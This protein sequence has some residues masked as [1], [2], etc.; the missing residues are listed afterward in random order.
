[1][2]PIQKT[3]GPFPAL[4][5]QIDGSIRPGLPFALRLPPNLL[6]PSE[7]IAGRYFLVRC[8]SNV[9][10]D[11]EGD[12]S[13]FLRRPLFVSGRQPREG[14]DNWQLYLP[15]DTPA[16]AESPT[17]PR[18]GAHVADAGF[19]WLAQR[20]QGGLLNLY[21]P[22]GNGFKLPT[23][24]HNLL[25]LVDHAH[26]PGWFWQ[27]FSL[28]E[29]TLDRG[30]RVTILLRSA[31]DRSVAD[32]IPLLPVQVEVRTASDESG[33]LEQLR[34]TVGWAHCI[35]A[36]VPPLRYGEILRVV[37]ESR[38]HIDKDFAQALARAD[39]LCGVGACLVCAV[40][41]ARGG[42]TR[43]CVHGPVFDLT[44]LVD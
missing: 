12:W 15:A 34:E 42:V 29:P 40:P 1:M 35:C 14:Y 27:L 16:N 39:L 28:C 17:S 8:S 7:I 24:S 31:S 11:R 2:M 26:D 23:A 37:Q 5:G 38:F 4:V 33:W 30:G 41:T 32:V 44:D 9:G 3:E 6:P 13:I 18:V 19:H 43:A 20:P 10:V 21:G 25:L 36:G 22:F